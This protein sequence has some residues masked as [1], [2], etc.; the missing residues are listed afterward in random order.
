MRFGVGLAL[1]LA[2]ELW[3]AL[4]GAATPARFRAAR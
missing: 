2:A 4:D 3:W 1:V